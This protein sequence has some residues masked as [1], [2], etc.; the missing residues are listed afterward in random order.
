VC[1]YVFEYRLKHSRI[2]LTQSDRLGSRYCAPI[3]TLLVMHLRNNWGRYIVYSIKV[4]Y[5]VT[6]CWSSTYKYVCVC[7]S[8]RIRYVGYWCGEYSWC[9]KLVRDAAE[10]ILFYVGAHTRI[11]KRFTKHNVNNFAADCVDIWTTLWSQK[12]QQ[13]GCVWYKQVSVF[14]GLDVIYK[15][16]DW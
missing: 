14:V 9:P 10:Y 4:L 5:I 7:N 1:I 8:G 13:N 15:A 11:N 12:L 6:R 2:H 3:L 16:V